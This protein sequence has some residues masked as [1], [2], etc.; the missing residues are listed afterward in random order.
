[1]SEAATATAERDAAMLMAER[2]ESVERAPFG[3]YQ[4]SRLAI[5]TRYSGFSR[6]AGS[7]S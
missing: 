4:A 3:G 6:S 1:M 7:I 2:V 5:R